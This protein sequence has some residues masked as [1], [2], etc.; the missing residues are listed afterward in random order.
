MSKVSLKFGPGEPSGFTDLMTATFNDAPPARILRELLQNSLDA[1]VEAGVQT[2]RV[3]FEVSFLKKADVPDLSGYTRTF[4][5]AVKYHRRVGNGRLSDP[6]Q[7]V[8]DTIESALEAESILTL[9]VLDNGVGFNKRRM[10]AVLSDGSGVKDNS[11][12]GSYGVGHFSAV[13]ASDLRYLLYGGVLK[14]GHRI[15]AGF[16]IVAGGPGKRYPRA[17]RGYLVKKALGGADSDRFKFAVGDEIPPII[18]SALSKIRKKWHHGSAVIIPAFNRFG[19]TPPLTEIIPLVAALN[20]SAAIHAGELVVEVALEDGTLRRVDRDNLKDL[21]ESVRDRVRSFRSDTSLGGLRPSGQVAWATY[22]ALVNGRQAEV[23][24]MMGK[25]DLRLL[26]PAP[27]ERTRLDLF[28]NGMWITD[29]IPELGPSAFDDRQEFHAVLMPSSGSELHRLI[30]KAE[31][32]MHDELSPKKR[33]NESEREQLGTALRAIAARLKSEVPTMKAETYSPDDFLVVPSD[34][35]GAVGGSA[36]YSLWGDPVIYAKAR[37]DQQRIDTVAGE[38]TRLEPGGRGGERSKT[39]RGRSSTQRSRPLP[40]RSTGVP[41]GPGRYSIEIEC[42]QPVD[43]VVLR[44]RIDENADATC[45]RLWQDEGVVLTAFAATDADG[46]AV[47]SQLESDAEDA[48]S[49]LIRL[50][51]LV[52]GTYRVSME[53]KVPPGFDEAVQAPVFR[54]DLHRPLD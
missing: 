17:A 14:T 27:L 23:A 28:R 33:L 2:A 5:G 41:D 3:R 9:S 53:Y 36:T 34:G 51:G 54:V 45:D 1:A 19:E 26:V 12:A 35:E 47:A 31:G 46:T 39:P 43:N 38:K 37:R 16:A 52:A 6:A 49:R 48:G 8:V 4:R 11:A 20:F 15:G 18:L 42:T 24:T 44:F 21:L 10:T 29:N 30:R 50:Q 40:F 13:A 25:A 22:Q 7:Q 32:P